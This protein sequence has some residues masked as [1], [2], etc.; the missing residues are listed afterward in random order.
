MVELDECFNWSK[1]LSKW[2]I[3]FA[4]TIIEPGHSIK[5]WNP[6]AVG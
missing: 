1:S 6:E 3:P 5:D 4:C 2:C